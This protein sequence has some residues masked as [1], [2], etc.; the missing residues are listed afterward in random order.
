VQDAARFYTAS[1]WV[2]MSRDPARLG[3]LTQ[4]RANPW[5]ALPRRAGFAPWTDDHASILAI[6]K[7]RP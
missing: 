1:I 3:R 4:D 6:L 2:A 7:I 5:Q